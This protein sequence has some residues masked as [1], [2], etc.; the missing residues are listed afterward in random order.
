M[1]SD[2][3]A[4]FIRLAEPAD[5]LALIALTAELQAYE[6]AFEP[7][8]SAPAQMAEP[9]LNEAWEWALGRRG[10]LFIACAASEQEEEEGAPIGFAI[11]GLAAGGADCLP[12]YVRVGTI[13][14]LIVAESWR[15]RGVGK[16]LIRCCE[17]AMREA[18]ALRIEIAALVGNA[19]AREAYAACG[20]HES[21]IV[22]GRYLGG[23]LAEEGSEE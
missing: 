13:T 3:A 9:Y 23:P 1:P 4:F 5:R 10:A 16:A 22:H 12:E 14:D 19:A 17:E 15:G 20:Y 6:M 18:G 2:D 21:Y 11:C 8:R 7:N